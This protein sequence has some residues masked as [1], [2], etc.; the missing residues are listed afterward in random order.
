MVQ[1]I[2]EKGILLKKPF[3]ESKIKTIQTLAC[4]KS[5]KNLFYIR[6]LGVLEATKDAGAM[7]ACA[8]VIRVCNACA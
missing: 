1:Y 3:A 6:K 4:A 7:S 5:K 2:F 8:N